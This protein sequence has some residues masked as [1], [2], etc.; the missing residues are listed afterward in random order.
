[1]K[2]PCSKPN[3]KAML[4]LTAAP[5]AGISTPIFRKLCRDQG[6]TLA[7]SEMV[8]SKGL[9][10]CN[11]KTAELLAL[12]NDERPAAA[13]L[14]G[15]DPAEMAEAALITQEQGF[16]VVDINMGCPVRKVVSVGSGCALMK[17]PIRAA[18]IV[19][20]MADRVDIP[21]TAKIRSGWDA[22]HINAP[23]LAAR[24]EDAGL[25][26]ITVHARTRDQ[27][28]S[29]AADWDLI[30]A[31]KNRVSLPVIGNGDVKDKDSALRLLHRTGCDGIMVGRAALGNPWVFASIRAA[32]EGRP[33]PEPP[34]RMDRYKVFL[35]HFRGLRLESGRDGAH[36][37]MKKFAAWYLKGFPGAPRARRKIH[38][39]ANRAEM[40]RAVEEVLLD[41][42][43][44][45]KHR[46]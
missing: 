15:P 20:V 45:P 17:D 43:H 35:R 40:V 5:M 23:D 6:A 7:F 30:A 36:H 37:E 12:G 4:R 10:R 1:M 18:R 13:Q 29:G 39:S 27:G 38:Q 34:D 19:R 16:D 14:F 9:V 26:A 2:M 42:P 32:L 8:S 44:R 24:L 28:Y 21:I 3:L 11:E 31:V 46:P 33:E 25:S 41:S 22:D